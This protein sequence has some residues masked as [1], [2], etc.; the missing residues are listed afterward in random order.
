MVGVLSMFYNTNL[1]VLFTKLIITFTT[2]TCIITTLTYIFEPG[3]DQ[4]VVFDSLC[5]FLADPHDSVAEFLGD[6]TVSTH[7][8]QFVHRAQL[9]EEDD[10]CV[11]D[12]LIIRGQNHVGDVTRLTVRLKEL[13]VL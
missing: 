7:V 3:V 8:T 2:L 10:D 12:V 6:G 11:D 5:Q 13:L 9:L 4:V 1:N